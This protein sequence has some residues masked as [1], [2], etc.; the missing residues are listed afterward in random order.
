[1]SGVSPPGNSLDEVNDSV[2][3][4]GADVGEGLANLLARIGEE[5]AYN[6]AKGNNA[7]RLGV[8]DGLRFAEDAIVKLLTHHGYGAQSQSRELD[9]S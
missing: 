3:E 6:D 1:M 9:V 2:S 8:H 7:F 4:Y 5:I